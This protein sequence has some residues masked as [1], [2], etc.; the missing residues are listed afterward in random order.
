VIRPRR[1]APRKAKK[2]PSFLYPELRAGLLK[3]P[4]TKDGFEGLIAGL[5]EAATGGR[6]ALMSSGDQGGIDSL[7][8][9]RMAAPRR[10]MQAKRYGAAS[11]KLNDLVG[12]MD[13]AAQAYP[14]IDCWILAT[15]LPVLGKERETLTVQAQRLG[16]GFIALDWSPGLYALPRL[17]VLCAAFPDITTQWPQLAPLRPSLEA[18][19]QEPRFS[20][21]RDLV[22][23][24]LQA[25]DA[26][27]IPAR[28][29]ASAYLE[30]AYDDP[31]AA[32][33]IA[34]ASPSFLKEA[35]PVGRAALQ[36]Q[37]LDWFTGLAQVLLLVGE[38]GMGKT[39][40]GLDALRTLG[41]E[42]AGPLPVVISSQRAAKNRDGLEALVSVLTEIG[43]HAGLRLP[44]P[45]DFW[46]HR[47]AC[48]SQT[49]EGLAP[50]ILVMVDGLDELD[51][52]PWPDWLA[53]LLTAE[54]R[55]LIRLVITCRTDDWLH[56]ITL[57][58]LEP[59]RLQVESVGRF[60]PDERD[61]YLTSRG[62]D[63][64][65]VSKPVLEAARHPRTAFHLTRLADEL[66]D[67]TGITRE[68]LL[69][70][71][72]QNR[73]FV[74]DG[75]LSS[76]SFHELVSEMAALAQEAA[77]RQERFLIGEGVVLERA[78]A[79][80]GY[81]KSRMRTVLSE[82]VSGRWCQRD[83]KAG[84]KLTFID[85]A[86]PDAVGMALAAQIR[87]MDVSGALVETDRFL[88][89]WAADDLVEPVLRMCA[90]ALVVD[91]MVPDALCAAI[92]ERWQRKPMHG[93]AGQDFW[94]RLHIFRPDLFLDFCARHGSRSSDWLIEWGIASFWEDYPAQ[95]ERIEQRVME[96]MSALP[97]P[98]VHASDQESYDRYMNRPRERQLRR[99]RIL[100]RLEPGAWQQRLGLEA[101]E[102]NND[103][104]RTAARIVGFLPRSS[105]VPAFVA[106]AITMAAAG[107]AVRDDDIAALVRDNDDRPDYDATLASL[108]SA[109]ATLEASGLDLGRTAA[110]HLLRATG[111]PADEVRARGL[112]PE[113]PKRR[114][115]SHATVRIN[116]QGEVDLTERGLGQEPYW[117][118][119]TLAEHAA[120]P[121]A[122]FSARTAKG[123]DSAFRRLQ[124]SDVPE[125]FQEKG[126]VLP[127]MLR[128]KP[129]ETIGLIRQ[130]L[131][132]ALLPPTGDTAGERAHDRYRQIALTALPFLTDG[133]RRQISLI[134]DANHGP[135][136]EGRGVAN[137]L[138][139]AHQPLSDQIR[140]LLDQPPVA[141]PRDYKY[142]LNEP[143][144]DEV[145]A[146]ILA[147]DFALGRD[148][149]WPL[150]S[151]ALALAKRFG[152]GKR[153]V[154]RSWRE[155]FAHADEEVR[156]M[157]IDLAR[158]VGGRAA[159]IELAATD[160]SAETA[161]NDLRAFEG[162]ELLLK[163]DNRR[164]RRHLHR[165][166]PENLA[167]TYLTRPSLR[168]DVYPLW[169][170]WM[171]DR[172]LVERTSRSFS[173]GYYRYNGRDKAYASF[174]AD[175]PEEVRRLLTTAW[176]TKGLRNNIRMDHDDGPAWSLLKAHARTDPDLFKTIWRETVGDSGNFWAGSIESLPA[177]LAGADF[178]DL[179]SEM[180]DRA[181]TDE[182]LFS[183]VRNLERHGHRK[184]LLSRIAT[185]L[186]SPRAIDQAQAMTIAGF[187]DGTRS[188]MRLWRQLAHS[189]PGPGWLAQVYKPAHAWFERVTL[190]RHWQRELSGALN[191]IDAFRAYWLSNAVVDDRFSLYF[192][193]G[194]YRVDPQSWRAQW[195]DFFLSVPKSFREA[196]REDIKNSHYHG[197]R[198]NNVLHGR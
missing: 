52:F 21:A 113:A 90:T 12:E 116:P 131:A 15:T 190:A 145:T 162:S 13:R 143:L 41:A 122:T 71:D 76:D 188:A 136:G 154:A 55:G 57:S 110:S 98:V 146:L 148:R 115:S 129:D 65:R 54:F 39:W 155:G 58:D 10:A 80:S 88:E 123:L 132:N 95:R 60:E 152:C 68:Q 193:T 4:A 28:S 100:E 140:L 7:G 92:L 182:K 120:D 89:P 48:W 72:F 2:P 196:A 103:R 127:T 121:R 70:R 35:P 111:L 3:L 14:G 11:L 175:H 147:V 169:H 104:I 67:L 34:G 8:D 66:G 6:L 180:L 101:D 174:Y 114:A 134:V 194:A 31:A 181:T 161:G 159:A 24:D 167:H 151:L 44:D 153:P 5:I 47:L 168:T 29:A 69:L 51:P 33:I 46:R 17:A 107:R 139:L 191:E 86:L 135:Q 170:A 108:Y 138:R 93:Q 118:F 94:R 9:A 171:V 85:A 184:L 185:G 189:P 83:P 42:S 40:A 141:W 49:E 16:W 156:S 179:H 195:L 81:E 84:N 192:K 50:C 96:W 59:D 91:E 74:K 119:A 166:C 22:I 63:P 186:A 75:L 172:L 124:P 137:A 112:R 62:V 144:G 53:P 73:R 130:Y 157:A 197:K 164:L 126:R 20:A 79:I 38:E 109:I 177:S 82:L 19:A 1:T 45:A 165:L 27:F 97:L 43:E 78:S 149:I 198:Y 183:A 77:L 173:G 36:S 128:W 18:L 64:E 176:E 99:L 23:R 133:E 158:I 30:R 102:E 26:G 106:W 163:L 32:R 187:L 61:N 105:F 178:D 56:R 87:A 150:L 142:L 37:A 117:L 125:W 160:W 25:A